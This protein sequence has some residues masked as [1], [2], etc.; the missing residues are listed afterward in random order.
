MTRRTEKWQGYELNSDILNNT[1]DDPGIQTKEN[2]MGGTN[3]AQG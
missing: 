2:K 1:D 3:S